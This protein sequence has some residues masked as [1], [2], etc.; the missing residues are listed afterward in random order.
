MKASTTNSSSPVFETDSDNFE[1]NSSSANLTLDR[2]GPI[3]RLL[4]I[5]LSRSR[6]RM[7]K[8]AREIQRSKPVKLDKK[9]FQMFQ[10]ILEQC[11][12]NEM[13][14]RNSGPC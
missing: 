7:Q 10:D 4:N 6:A 14:K 9:T 8:R 5:N 1:T 2:R 11:K 13:D 12:Q 3:E